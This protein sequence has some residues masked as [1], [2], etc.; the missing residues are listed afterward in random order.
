MNIL[1]TG[2]T[3]F[4]GKS[5]IENFSKSNLS[6]IN[7]KL[8]DLTKSV[9]KLKDNL[10]L[11]IHS[12]GL[13]HQAENRFINAN[14]F[15]NVNVIGTINLCRGL[16]KVKLKYFVYISSVSVYGLEEGINVSEESNL[17]FG[18]PYGSSKIISEKYLLEWCKNNGVILTILRLPL[19]FHTD[20]PGNIKKMREAIKRGY[21][22]NIKQ[23][24]SRKSLI[25]LND[26]SKAIKLCY[27]EGGTYNVTDGRDY[28][29]NDISNYF[30]NS[31]G[32]KNIELPLYLVRFLGFL[33][34]FI[35]L[36]PVNSKTIDKMT[37]TLTFCNKKI[38]KKF[39]FRT[40]KIF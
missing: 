9:P 1:L 38:T 15:Y 7:S 36:L 24:N 19:V 22:F 34:D 10:D 5:I 21:F 14:Q 29:F 18:E 8:C 13:A 20:A 23:N 32:N 28:K 35:K 27:K 3:G 16:E 2:S 11:C 25:H 12:A 37:K 17:I 39:N 30:A 33:G 26:V 6:L 31:M 4:I 40:K